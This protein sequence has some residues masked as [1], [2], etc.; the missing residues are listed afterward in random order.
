MPRMT[1]AMSVGSTL[2]PSCGSSRIV[3]GTAIPISASDGMAR[4]RLAAL[5]AIRSPRRVCPT[6][7]PIGIAMRQAISEAGQ[8]QRDVLAQCAPGSRSART[9]SPGFV[10]QAMVSVMTVMPAS[11]RARSGWISAARVQGVARRWTATSDRSTATAS[12]IDGTAPNSISVGKKCRQPSK[13]KKP[14]PPNRSPI[15][16]VI[17]TSP[18]VDTQATRSPAMISG[19]ASGSSTRHSRCRRHVAHAVG[20]LEHVARD[21]VE[22]RDRVPDEDQ[23]RV[24][25]ER[26]L[27]GE[28]RD[29]RDRDQRGEQREARDRVQDPA[30]RR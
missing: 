23:Q 13:M 24:Q 10:S 28:Q 18:I 2:N 9:S 29:A 22:A 15:V 8:R 20:G 7:R 14:R 4:P 26:D 6:H 1:T 25:D 21:G 3:N 30:E 11:P 5:I 17:A 19:V 16:A 27:R 12:S